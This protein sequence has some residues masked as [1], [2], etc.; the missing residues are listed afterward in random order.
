[1]GQHINPR[2]AA[3]LA[4]AMTPDA[5]CW[6]LDLPFGP[7][8][9]CRGRSHQDREEAA[10]DWL[11]DARLFD[12]DGITALGFATIAAAESLH[13]INRRRATA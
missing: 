9:R 3:V 8:A 10:I 13:G 5:R 1:M 2:R 4:R 6:L 12:E 7:D 11:C